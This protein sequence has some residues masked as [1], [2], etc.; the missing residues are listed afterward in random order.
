MKALNIP[1]SFFAIAIVA[2]LCACEDDDNNNNNNNVQGQQFAPLTVA[3]LTDINAVY[4]IN[5]AGVGVTTL[6]FPAPGQYQTI[7]NGETV[8]GTISNLQRNGN[9]WTATLTPDPNQQGA[10]AGALTLAWTGNN[11]GTYTF[12]PQGGAAQSGTFTVTQINLTG[13]NTNTNVNPNPGPTNSSGPGTTSLFGK[14]LQLTYQ[15]GGGERFVFNSATTALYENGVDTATYT[16]DTASGQ[17]GITRSGGQTYRLVIP[18]GSSNG[19]TSITYQEPGGNSEVS[20]ASYT[21]Q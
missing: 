16:Y 11:A 2:L 8:N 5:I 3:A 6:R 4:T 21:L 13:G 15:G 12:Q 14:T 10:E 1:V 20:T 18:S 9:T 7:L 17:L 19:M